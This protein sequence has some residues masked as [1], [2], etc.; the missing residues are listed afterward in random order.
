[1]ISMEL[2]FAAIIDS[3]IE[4]IKDTASNPV[5][6]SEILSH[7]FFSKPIQLLKL[8]SI[9]A[10]LRDQ[11]KVAKIVE[12]VGDRP[13]LRDPATLEILLGLKQVNLKQFV[14]LSSEVEIC[15]KAFFDTSSVA[16]DEMKRVSLICKVQLIKYSALKG[17]WQL[18]QLIVSGLDKHEKSVVEDFIVSLGRFAAEFLDRLK[19]NADHETWINYCKT[20][21]DHLCDKSP[22]QLVVIR[23]CRALLTANRGDLDEAA[24]ILREQKKGDLPLSVSISMRRALRDREYELAITLADRLIPMSRPTSGMSEFSR[25]TAEFAL[26]RINNL[27][28]SSGLNPF[29]ISGTLL[30][31]IREGRIFEHD[32]DFDIGILGWESQ[33]DVAAALLK[34]GE[35]AFS[36]KDLR[37]NK[38]YLLP[39]RHVPTG[40][41]FDIFF[42]HDKGDHFLHGIDSRLGYTLNYRFSKF[43]LVSRDFIGDR[44]LIPDNFETMLAENYGPDW[45]I[46]DPHYFVMLQSPALVKNAGDLSGFVARHEM[47]NLIHKRGSHEKANAL[48]DCISNYV[49]KIFQPSLKTVSHFRKVIENGLRLDVP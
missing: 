2:E 5:K 22:P 10:I 11:E 43:D 42:F 28:T 17:N 4:A 15:V 12:A 8:T 49:P 39:V 45:R 27:L 25:D 35:F 19:A 7:E 44:F 34:S 33:Y 26:K 32:K 23:S 30:G 24:R 48:I 29:L 37:A 41:D 20:V 13:S 14:G 36:V 21:E 16:L 18:I 40:F 3:D 1:M 47:L 6:F 9:L 46:P 31:C 38:L